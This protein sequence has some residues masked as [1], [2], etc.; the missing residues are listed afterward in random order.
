MKQVIQRLFWLWMVSALSLTSFVM[1]AWLDIKDLY[2]DDGTIQT[3][4]I[5]D[6]ISDEV[7][8]WD[9]FNAGLDLLTW[10]DVPDGIIVGEVDNVDAA[11]ETIAQ[12]IQTIINY[13]LA[14][15]GLV[16]LV[17]LL[18]HGFLVLTAGDNEERAGAGWKGIKYATIAI[19]G[20]ALSWTIISFVFYAIFTV[21]WSVW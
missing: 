5:K 20:I 18:Y 11:R 1:S 6:V 8:D 16:A 7:N 14:L 17:Y 4:K 19:L 15:V 21:V 3:N 12:L 10:E 2:G 9:W 13:A